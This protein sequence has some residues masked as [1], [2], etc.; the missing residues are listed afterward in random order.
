MKSPAKTYHF[1]SSKL[2]SYLF[3]DEMCIQD[4]NTYDMGASHEYI[5]FLN[6]F[7]FSSNHLHP[8]LIKKHDIACLNLAFGGRDCILGS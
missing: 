5:F 8:S 4:I 7:L 6:F 3:S 2:S 1:F